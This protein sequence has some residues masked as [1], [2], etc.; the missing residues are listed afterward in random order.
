[1]PRIAACYT[2]IWLYYVTEK[3]SCSSFTLSMQFFNELFQERMLIKILKSVICITNS[4]ANEVLIF[5]K[6]PRPA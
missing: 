6:A 5:G 1:M 3:M 4:P 2:L